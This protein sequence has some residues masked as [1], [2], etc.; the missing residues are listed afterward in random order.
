MK[1]RVLRLL[2][3]AAQTSKEIIYFVRWL[4]SFLMTAKGHSRIRIR[5]KVIIVGNGPGVAYFPFARLK[6]KYDFCCV[7]WFALNSE[8]FMRIRPRYYVLIDPAFFKESEKNSR[9]WEVFHTVDWPMYLISYSDITFP[10]KNKYVKQLG[11]NRNYYGG[12][13]NFLKKF[14][15][16]R[17]TGTC[18]YQNVIVCAIFFFIMNRAG[19]VYLTGVENDW[20]K[21]YVIG[22]D[23]R[24]Y[25]E[26]VHFYGRERLKM[27]MFQ[28]GDFYRCIYEYY[29]TMYQYH[30]LG[31]YA[32][33]NKVRIYNTTQ[34]SY[35]DVF[36]K[37]GVD[38]LF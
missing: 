14:V 29:M 38:E 9:L 15:F 8:D 5:K 19:D 24:I 35:I 11:M 36:E 3:Q 32:G 23:N 4:V 12:E 34:N 31:Q 30:I 37:C 25:R 33:A 6:G 2:F 17:N 20:H 16:N 26:C 22:E 18:G 7:N 27:E 10:V 13:F 1:Q 28:K 21:E